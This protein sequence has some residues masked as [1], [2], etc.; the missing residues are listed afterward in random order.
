MIL[1]KLDAN[2]SLQ[3]WSIMADFT[4]GLL[5][6]QYGKCGG[7]MQTQSEHVELNQSGRN[8][9]DQ[10]QLRY[11]SRVAKQFA[12]GYRM[13]KE[14]AIQFANLNELNFK[15]PMLAKQLDK[16]KHPDLT[17]A[18]LQRKLDG[19]R[20]LIT[21]QNGVLHAYSRNGK[22]IETLDHI[23]DDIPDSLP[24]G[25][26]L[27]GEV[28][29][30]GMALKDI[31]SRIKKLQPET[32]EL[33]YHIYDVISSDSFVPRYRRLFNYDY[34]NSIIIEPYWDANEDVSLLFKT[35]R[36]QGYEGLMLR[37]DNCG[38]E[39][40][41]RSSNLLKIKERHDAEYP[42]VGI[43][44]AKNE[45]AVLV[46]A[47]NEE[48]TFKCVAPGTIYEKQQ[49]ASNPQDY[50]GLFVTVSYAYLTDY[51]VPFHPVAERF[52]D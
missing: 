9:R 32:A 36:E 20:L 33:N 48:T 4:F 21:K 35:A 38:Y 15:K 23:L 49:I 31:N 11:N 6:I 18:V 25:T 46:L 10:V 52:R 28:Y 29:V 30:H 7:K 26:T 13:T 34:G 16:V 44:V 12:K 24:E 41:K 3:E 42:V 19:N 22:I 45:T 51:G 17:G 2:K 43:E 5:T 8:I 40:G 27:D 14:E 39:V 47:L 37:L 1:Y 50:I